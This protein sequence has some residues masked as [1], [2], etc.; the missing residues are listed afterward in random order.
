MKARDKR[1]VMALFQGRSRCLVACYRLGWRLS[2][3]SGAIVIEGERFGS[4]NSTS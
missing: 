2:M 1:E 3:L 4:P